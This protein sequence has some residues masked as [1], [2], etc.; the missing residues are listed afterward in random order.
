MSEKTEK[1]TPKK[2]RDARKKGQVAHSKELVSTAL[3]IAIYGL[4]FATGY[5]L[6]QELQ[7]L[8]ALPAQFY[9]LP[10]QEALKEMLNGVAE[11][12]LG[13]L[14]PFILLVIV[15]AISANV[16]HVGPLFALESVKFDLKKISPVEGIKKL[17]SMKSLVELIKSIFKIIFLSILIYWVIQSNLDD[18]IK[19]PYCG[20]AC[21]LPFIGHLMFELA[22]VSIIAFIIVALIDFL[23]QKHD[24]QKKLRM[25]KDE[26]KREYKDTEGNPEIIGQRKQIHR[27]LLEGGMI[28]QIKKASVIVTNPTHLALGIYYD[29][30]K[31]SLPIVT[32]KAKNHIAQRVKKIAAREGVPIL[33]N[34]PLARALYA[35]AELDNYIPSDLIEPVAEVLKWVASLESQEH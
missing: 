1:P 6:V 28:G 23:Y 13:I 3:M 15:V 8:I 22:V 18:I 25:T 17:F 32:V 9:E 30:D 16:G 33:E 12:T 29:G 14:M 27:E 5:H 31:R 7:N 26:V 20:S 10:F 34:V 11:K 24:H 2:L 4:L 21:V 19:L 35:E